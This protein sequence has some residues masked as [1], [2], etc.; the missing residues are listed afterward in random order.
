[1]IEIKKTKSIN[2]KS[3]LIFLVNDKIDLSKILTKEENL[4]FN[5]K[6]KQGD[7]SVTLN[8]FSSIV[9]IQIIKNEKFE[10]KTLE[11]IRKSANNF[12]CL[13]SENK[14]QKITIVD[15]INNKNYLL[16][17]AEGL[18]LSD[19]KF[20]K[21]FT[22]NQ[23]LKSSLSE[24][25]LNNIDL[26]DENIS[27]LKNICTAV[28]K[29]RDLVNEPNSYLTATKMADEFELIGKKV[30][31]K[32]EVFGKRKIEALKMGG[33]L[34]VN[35]GSAEPP[36]FS[37]IEWKPKNA[38]NKKP[39][40][41]VGKGIVFDTGGLSL[42]P[43][44]GSMDL[45][46][47]DMGGAAAVFGTMHAIALQKLPIHIIALI[48]STDNRPGL[49]AYAPQDV[50]FMHNGMTVEVLNTDAEGRMVLADALS[51]AQQ[52]KPEL[53][54]E[55][56]TLTGAAHAAI[57]HW[58]IVGMGNTSKK[59]FAELQKS[60]ENVYER[61]VEFPFWEEYDELLKSDIADLKNIGGKLAGAITAGKFLEH[62]TNYPYIHLD[63]A[64]PA[65]MESKDSYRGKGGSGVGVRL[66]YNF[67]K[68]L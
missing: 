18:I 62:F 46:K 68:N 10:F 37:V 58:G 40:V 14:I 31:L 25:S 65:F 52:Y 48:P 28:Y 61:I 60:G 19:Y 55:L 45:M 27:E 26:S 5:K 33:L 39:Y 59:V 11:N 67:F 15:L 64:G 22:K 36:R 51:F 44:A 4:Y 34:A 42:K 9:N 13:I 43:T 50:I 23:K 49:N 63:I 3:N 7:C 38:K 1:M 16:A 2:Q 35:K 57:G 41:L 30:G 6:K 32:V 17:F 21:Y 20:I 53:V 56:S 54:I 12:Y 24:I 47:S 8:R 66:L 29:S